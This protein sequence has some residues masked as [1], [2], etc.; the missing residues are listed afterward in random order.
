MKTFSDFL[1]NLHKAYSVDQGGS[2]M[3]RSKSMLVIEKG[4]NPSNKNKSFWDV[5]KG[6]C[7]SYPEGVAEL[8]DV[9]RT[10]VSSWAAKID[11][12]M[13]DVQRKQTEPKDRANVIVTGNQPIAAAAEASPHD[14]PDTRIT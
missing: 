1:E 6:L 11:S 8:L 2:D 5:F 13:L 7:S 9:D 4:L 10:K 3:P 12:S 14:T